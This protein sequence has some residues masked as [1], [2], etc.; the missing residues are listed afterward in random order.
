MP[1]KRLSMRKI[2]EVLR[3]KQEKK[4]SSRKIADVCG[5][6]R[7]TVGEYLRRAEVA[8][9]S[10]PLPADLSDTD[11]ERRL[12]PPQETLPS[13]DRGSPDWNYINKEMKRP[14]VTLELLWQEYRESHPEGYQYSWFCEHYREWRGKLDL[15]MRQ[16]HRAGEKLFVDYAGQTVPIVDR[17]TG[18]ARFA[19]IFVAVMGASNYTY[20]EATWSQKLPDWIGSHMRCFQFLGGVPEI[21]VP[22]NLKSGVH[23]AHLYEPD[24]NP[25]YQDMA[26]HYGV[27]IIPARSR[28]PKDK[29]K[30]EVGVQIVERM[31]LA[32]LRN[33]TFF[34]LGQLNSAIKELLDTVN[35]RAFKKLPGNRLEQFEV[36]DKP[37]LSPL[38]LSPYL[39]AEWKKARVHID[40]HVEIDGHYY[41]VPHTLVKRQIDVRITQNTIECF[42]QGE[43][44]TS[45]RRS[46]QKG[47][48]TT[49]TAHMPESHRQQ[50]EWT[51]QR[52]INWAAKSGKATE[53][54]I[55]KI[56][57]SRKHPQQGFR[58]C[59]GIL[60]LG[61][62]YSC[63]RLERSCQ[64]ALA[65]GTCNYKSIESI[66]KNGLD[67]RPLQEEVIEAQQLELVPP[68]E[69][70][71][72]RGAHY[73]H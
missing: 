51:P 73:Y 43:R 9:I 23:K 62:R 42:H 15:V 45:H 26:A 36:I 70:D 18:E 27:A 54:V 65:F 49:Q 66:L 22:D 67:Q 2:K 52:L 47:G 25:T 17:T 6:A 30:A 60:R 12:F 38:P 3:L 13:G 72:I 16:T 37:A 34:S 33:R 4:I 50:G 64:R 41:S 11:L 71:N 58:S 44:V 20:A 21:V 28:R 46:Y 69:H 68:T 19:Q 57:S 32:V 14:G 8:G 1:A 63:E 61:E 39:F 5:I 31:I 35:R 7:S 29:A 10:W 59:L 48:H 40:Y 55:A 56:L 53:Q 24:L